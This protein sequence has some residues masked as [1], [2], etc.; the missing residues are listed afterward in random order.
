MHYIQETVDHLRA[1]A[2]HIIETA[3]AIDSI[4]S[5]TWNPPNEAPPPA[6]QR[7]EPDLA[8]S[9]QK[10]ASALTAQKTACRTVLNKRIESQPDDEFNSRTIAK[11]AGTT[12]TIASRIIDNYVSQGRLY[13]V[14]IGLYRPVLDTKRHRKRAGVAERYA[15]F[16]SDNPTPPSA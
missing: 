5:S 10:T 2:R 4:R 16:R 3:D 15:Q 9:G 6:P 12:A 14:K 7:P 11:E 1:M 8:G 13:R